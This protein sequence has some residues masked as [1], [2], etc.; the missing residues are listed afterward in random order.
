[1]DI[2]DIINQ[3]QSNQDAMILLWKIANFEIDVD[4]TDSMLAINTLKKFALEWNIHSLE[5]LR[6]LAIF[7]ANITALSFL[8][9]NFKDMLLDI[10]R[11]AHT[12]WYVN[13]FHKPSPQIIPNQKK[14]SRTT[15]CYSC[16]KQ[17][18]N[19]DYWSCGACGWIVCPFCGSCWCGFQK[20][21]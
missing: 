17:L 4:F 3:S 2:Q 19:I 14:S 8:E 20:D 15:S 18:N 16:K 10:T 13:K 6:N 9:K 11:Q 1:M 5:V 12:N 21:L 7:W